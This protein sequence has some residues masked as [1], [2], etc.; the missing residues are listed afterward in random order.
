MRAS[1]AFSRACR[2]GRAPQEGQPRGLGP[3]EERDGALELAQVAVQ[4]VGGQLRQPVSGLLDGRGLP[5]GGDVGGHRL[6]LTWAPW[7]RDLAIQRARPVTES[8]GVTRLLTS[9][10]P[11]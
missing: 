3:L 2:R 7:R 9:A 1:S 4:F 10:E 11:T 6:V 8:G 5:C